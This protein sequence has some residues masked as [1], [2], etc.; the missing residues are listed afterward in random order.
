MNEKKE[1]FISVDVETS[2]PIPGEYSLLQIG[3]CLIENVQESISLYLK[4]ITKNVVAAAIQV[5]GLDMHSLELGGIEPKEAMNQFQKWIANVAGAESVPV[6]VGLNAGF[7]WSF[8]NYY[9]HRYLGD[10]PF[11]Y[12]ALDLKS[13]YLG[14]VGGAWATTGARQIA[15]HYHLS[16][17]GDHDA[18]H[19]AQFQA[20]L[21]RLI[22]DA[23]DRA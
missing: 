15:E 3:A 14:A 8:V 16:G 10:N 11:G 6:F 19:D 7:D 17:H 9:F 4:P 2:G 5:T 12:S 20:D 21:F 1:L 18:L 13:M 22:R 23:S